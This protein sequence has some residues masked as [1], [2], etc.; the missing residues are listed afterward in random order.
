MERSVLNIVT[1]LLITARL[2]AAND[3]RFGLSE[4]NEN[5]LIKNEL[6]DLA[7]WHLPTATPPVIANLNGLTLLLEIFIFNFFLLQSRTILNIFLCF[8]LR[9]SINLDNSSSDISGKTTCL[10]LKRIWLITFYN[11]CG[12]TFPHVTHHFCFRNNTLTERISKYPWQTVFNM[13]GWKFHYLWWNIIYLSI[14]FVMF[15][16]IN[17]F[18]TSAGIVSLRKKLWLSG[19]FR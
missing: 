14:A 8:E 7:K 5:V 17:D 13:F 3:N 1:S 9:L 16:S 10:I 11:W 15:V 2:A 4:W 6:T 18:C 12:F 19:S